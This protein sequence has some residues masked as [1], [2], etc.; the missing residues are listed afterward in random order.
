MKMETNNTEKQ[1]VIILTELLFKQY[2]SLILPPKT[3]SQLVK[4]SEV[5]LRKDRTDA[6]GIPYTKSGK[7][8]GSDRVGYNI[9]DVAEY[10]VAKKIKTFC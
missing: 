7:G 6:T 9:Y 8:S 5:S 1:E 2:K 4:R 10:V 3:V